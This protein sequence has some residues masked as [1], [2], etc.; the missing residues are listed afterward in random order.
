MTRVARN[1]RAYRERRREGL[2][3]FAVTLR[4]DR[5]ADL[6][7]ATRL[8]SPTEADDPAALRSGLEQFLKL[9]LDVVTD[10]YSP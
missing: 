5:L 3:V 7:T 9:Q 10:N 1:M 2:K 8:I 4:E 6:L